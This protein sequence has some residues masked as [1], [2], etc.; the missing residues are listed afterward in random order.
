MLT[1]PRSTSKFG[2]PHHRHLT[3]SR[4]RTPQRLDSISEGVEPM[5]T[6]PRLRTAGIVTAGLVLLAWNVVPLEAQHP[7]GSARGGG[8]VR[9][10]GAFGGGGANDGASPAVPTLHVVPRVTEKSAWT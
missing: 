5:R 9:R 4:A 8:V 1:A 3:P 10:V 6:S 7:A 2:E